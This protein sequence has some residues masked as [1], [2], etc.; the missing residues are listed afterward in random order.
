MENDSIRSSGSN[1]LVDVWIDG[2]MR[3]ISV[4]REAIGAF[5][6]FE[7]T[8]RMSESDRCE[9]VRT[10]L[11]L[12]VAA[13]KTRLRDTNPDADAVALDAGHLPR[14]DGR[15][16]DRRKAVRRKT[17]RRKADSPS[18][19]QPERRRANRRQGTRRAKSPKSPES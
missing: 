18:A 7:R 1:T 9:F 13:A 4:S 15:S 19:H 10:H 2:K 14:S 3:A 17:E 11:P 16:G 5:L 8:P 12:L 6:G